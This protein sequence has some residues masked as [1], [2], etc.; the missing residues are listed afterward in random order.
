MTK[1]DQHSYSQFYVFVDLLATFSAKRSITLHFRHYTIMFQIKMQT[2]N[3]TTNMEYM[4]LNMREIQTVKS[5]FYL[6]IRIYESISPA[7]FED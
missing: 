5:Q 1:E 6:T 2:L 7:V 3:I 4:T